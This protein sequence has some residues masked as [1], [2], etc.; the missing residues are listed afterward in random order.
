MNIR[1]FLVPEVRGGFDTYLAEIQKHGAVN[2]RLLVQTA[3]GERRIWEY[4]NTLRTKGV[5]AP[6]VRGMARDITEHK[7]AEDRLVL[8][9]RKYR[10]MFDLAPVGIYQSTLEGRFISVNKALTRI[11]GYD[12]PDEMMHLDM[13]NDVYFDKQQRAALIAQFEPEGSV[14]DHEILWKKKNGVPV[15]VQLNARAVKDMDGKTLHFEAFI[16]DIT[17]RKKAERALWDSEQ[18][19]RSQFDGFPLPT[20]TWQ[21][22]G[23]QIV[24]VGYNAAADHVTKHGVQKLMGK[25][26]LELYL[27]RPDI[28]DDFKRCLDT[29]EPI[30]REMSYRFQYS[31]QER[32][33][34]V[35]FVFVPPD[36][37]MVHTEDITERKRAD[38]ELQK[39]SRAVE[40]TADSLLITDKEGIIEYVNTAFVKMTGYSGEEVIGKTPRIL[41]SGTHNQTFYQNLWKTIGRGDTFESVLVNRK[42]NGELYPEEKTIV[43]MKDQNGNITHYLSAGMDITE[44]ERAEEVARTYSERLEVLSKQLLEIQENERRSLARE[45][46][47]EIGQALT[48]LKIHL[49]MSSRTN[50]D[51]AKQNVKDAEKIAGD[52]VKRIRGISLD[53]RPAMLDDLGLVPAMRWHL[54]EH[55]GKAGIKAHF[56]AEPEEIQVSR[57][58]ATVCFRVAQEALTNVLRHSKAKSVEVQLVKRGSNLEVV[59]SDDGRGFDVESAIR[60]SSAGKSFGLLGMQERVRLVGGDLAI[61]SEQGSG[62]T[63]KATFPDKIAASS[64]DSGRLVK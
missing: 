38:Q 11:L 46:H 41:K 9:E 24:L 58:I 59:I 15:W 33:L 64:T 6:I 23:E 36:L 45:L 20:Y 42:K 32:E 40:Q 29:R 52:L 55:T 63:I 37:V 60:H 1:D 19:F 43:P 14:A 4:S 39:L 53:L 5:D 21:L 22:Q 8:S 47:D 57:E 12:S 25:T 16:R 17:D 28:V 50:V 13:A 51:T 26:V 48:S 3:A 49:E 31:G 56:T 35:D 30:H 7:Q 10:E 34:S 18:R 2:G 54:L 44:R 61:L 27:D 62:S